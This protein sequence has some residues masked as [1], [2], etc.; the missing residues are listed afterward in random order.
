[1]SRPGEDASWGG[2]TGRAVDIL[3]KHADRLG[4]TPGDCTSYVCGN[5]DMVAQA[6]GVLTRAGFP[7]ES[8]RMERY[9]RGVVGRT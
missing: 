4:Y 7:P 1:M 6:A 3:R 8:V 9:L 2:E 5:P